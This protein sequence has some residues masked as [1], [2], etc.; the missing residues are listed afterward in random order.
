MN[1]PT[2]RQRGPARGEQ[3]TIAVAAAVSGNI[4]LTTFLLG[5]YYA[6]A[7]GAVGMIVVTNAGSTIGN[8]FPSLSGQ[9]ARR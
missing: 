9:P 5:G 8:L 6:T 4:L 3:E 1:S 2:T 7:L